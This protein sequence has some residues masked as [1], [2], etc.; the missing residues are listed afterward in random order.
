MSDRKAL[1]LGLALFTWSVL[2]TATALAGPE[3]TIYLTKEV[4]DGVPLNKPREEFSCS[5]KIY[6]VLELNGLAK[7]RYHLEAIWRGPRGKDQEHTEYPF[8][9]V[10]Q[11]ERVWVWLK[12]HRSPE[13]ALVQ[14]ANPSAGMD[15]FIG[16]WKIRLLLNG[17]PVASKEFSV[18]C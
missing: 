11:K 5:D 18:L 17:K 4:K 3:H 8:T 15:E 14:F 16:K 6:A 7:G 10:R 2:M 12:L 9:A 1:G 13:A